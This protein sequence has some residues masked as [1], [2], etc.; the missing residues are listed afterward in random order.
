MLAAHPCGSS[1]RRGIN[2]RIDRNAED[3]GP[4]QRISADR[5][6]PQLG[7]VEHRFLDVEGL[8]VHVAEAG[9]GEPL[10]PLHTFV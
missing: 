2:E 10:V 9:A 7:G 1:R 8:R 4:L 6:I 5:P 3:F